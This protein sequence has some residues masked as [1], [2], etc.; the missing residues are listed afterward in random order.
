VNIY[1]NNLPQGSNAQIVLYDTNGK[2][3]RRALLN[4]EGSGFA[5]IDVRALS[6]GVYSYSLLVK[7][8]LAESK[9]MEVA[10]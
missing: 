4:K 9:T 2:V 6:A 10:R 1:Y 5:N 3:V 7:G 8:K